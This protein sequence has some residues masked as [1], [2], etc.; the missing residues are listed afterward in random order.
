ML[1]AMQMDQ[2]FIHAR[3]N[4]GAS[5]LR[6]S[7]INGVSI[8]GATAALFGS[9]EEKEKKKETSERKSCV[10][11]RKYGIEKARTPLAALLSPRMGRREKKKK[12][13]AEEVGSHGV[14]ESA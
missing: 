7:R 10:H 3:F 6:T 11:V 1:K 5:S 14:Y 12:K 8:S 13:S 9:I 4:R 2:G